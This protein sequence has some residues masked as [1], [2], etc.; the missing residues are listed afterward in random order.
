MSKGQSCTAQSSVKMGYI[1]QNV[2]NTLRNITLYKHPYKSHTLS[3]PKQRPVDL[4]VVKLALVKF[5]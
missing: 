3:G 5:V 1:L 4:C 2:F